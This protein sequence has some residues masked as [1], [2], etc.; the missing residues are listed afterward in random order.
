MV[1]GSEDP[2]ANLREQLHRAYLLKTT[3]GLLDWDQQVNLPA[4]SAALRSQQSALLA[5]LHH[6]AAVSSRLREALEAAGRS[7]PGTDDDRAAVVRLARI[8]YERATRLTP[9]FV[10]E[11]TEH[12]NRSYHAWARARE[13]NDFGSFAPFLERT[14]EFAREEAVLQGW[15]ERPYDYHIDLHDPGLD[16]ATVESLFNRLKG[17]LLELAGKLLGAPIDIDDTLF[18]GFPA[19]DQERFALRVT[20]KL[21]FDYRRGRLDRSLHPFC[22]GDGHDTRMTTRFDPDNPLDSLFSAIHETG[23]GL[24]GQGLPLDEAAT[25]LGEPVG[26]AIH[27]SQSRLWENQVGRGRPFWRYF[28]PLYRETF[29]EQLRHIPDEELYRAI[30]RVSLNPIRVDSDEV[31][32]NLHIL[33]RFELEKALFDGRIQVNELPREWNRLSESLIGVKPKNDAEG[34]LQDIHW[35]GGAFGYFPSYTLGNMIAAQLWY[36]VREEIPALEEGFARGNFQ[37]LLQWLRDNI[38]RHGR[39]YDTGELVKRVTG[40]PISPD[41]LLRYL[42]ERYLPLHR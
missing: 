41:F 32:Y 15:R 20:E 35:S 24:Y 14:L 37:P 1:P 11:K 22:S 33:L 29:P 13:T 25:P 2:Y 30:N 16:A 5:T 4:G 18:H 7:T 23:H 40:N 34:V 9:A 6:E 28:S 10:R 36:R 12:Q 21:G 27:E 17:P 31:T 42:E 38:H 3:L 19:H 8:D 39:R 26:M